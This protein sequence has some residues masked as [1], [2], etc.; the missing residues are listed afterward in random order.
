MGFI[1]DPHEELKSCMVKRDEAKGMAIRSGSSFKLDGFCWCTA[2]FKSYRRFSIGLRSGLWL[3]H[4]NTCKCFPLNHSS[5]A[6][7]VCLGSL[8][9][10][11]V[12]LCPSPKSLEDW[13]RFPSRSSLYLECDVEVRHWPRAAFGSLTHTH[14]HHSSLRH[15]TIS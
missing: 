3:G 15:Y 11:K 10:W 1:M 5:V 9:C 8:S 12:N 14:I 13:N 6:I 4:S 7:A 2:I